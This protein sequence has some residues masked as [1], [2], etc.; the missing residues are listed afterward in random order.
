MNDPDPV[1]KW[2]TMRYVAWLIFTNPISILATL[3]AIFQAL[4]LDPSMV[5]HTTVHVISICNLVL[6][7]VI[8]QIRKGKSSPPP[9]SKGP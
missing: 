8:A 3:Q 6:I 1:P 2:F 7:V 5:S 4:T 9:P